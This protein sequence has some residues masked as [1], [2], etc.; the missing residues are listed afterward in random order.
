MSAKPAQ[1]LAALDEEPS[2]EV[3]SEPIKELPGTIH[4]LEVS[5][6]P[7]ANLSPAALGQ[8]GLAQIE[9]IEG[10]RAMVRVGGASFVAGIDGH[11]D[12]IVIAS[13]LERAEPVLVEKRGDNLYVVGALRTRATP[14]VDKMKEVTIEAETIDLRASNQAT[15]RSGPAVL[16]VRAIGEI[17]TYA[18]KILSRAEGVHKIIGRM[19]RLN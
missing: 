1:A 18:E 17:E 3:P 10:Q 2:V 16:A 9:S 13:A 14:G 8:L 12:P 15:V 5:T 7:A 11:V 4:E 19:L 6:A